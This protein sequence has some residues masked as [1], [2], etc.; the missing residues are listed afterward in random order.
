MSQTGRRV[1]GVA[2]VAAATDVLLEALDA[3]PEGIAIFGADGGLL[4]WNSRYVEVYAHPPGFLRPGLPFEAVVRRIAASGRVPVAIGREGEWIAERLRHQAMPESDFEHRLDDGRWIRVQEKR[5]RNGLTVGIRVDITDLKRREA[6]FRLMF[7]TNPVPILVRDRDGF[8]M[9]AV[10]DAALKLFGYG[11]AAFLALKVGD[12]CALGR[13]APLAEGA[14]WRCVR[15]DGTFVDLLPYSSDFVHAGRPAVIT[16]LVDMTE[17]QRG[18]DDL[19]RTRAF[20][21]SVIETIPSIVFAKDMQDGGRYVLFNR[22]GELQAADDLGRIVGRTDAEIFPPDLATL[23]EDHDAE[24][25]RAG[26][27]CEYEFAAPGRGGSRRVIHTRKVPIAGRAGEAPRYVLGVAEDVTER[28]EMERRLDRAARFDD[29]TGLPNRAAFAGILKGALAARRRTPEGLAL[30]LIDLDGFRVFN[31]ALGHAVGDA[32]LK[33]VGERLAGEMRGDDG[34]ARLGAD[35]FVVVQSGVGERADA[36]SLASR[37]LDLFTRPFPVCGQELMVGATIGIALAPSE[38][39]AEGGADLL[40][41]HAEL[42]LQR[43][44]AGHRGTFHAFEPRMDEEVRGRRALEQDLRGALERG[45]FELHYQPQVDLATELVSGFEALVRWRHPVRG[46]VEPGAFIPVAEETG[47]IVRLGAWVLARACADAAAWPVP[48]RV[49]VNL[50]PVQFITPG[51]PEAVA[52]A[53]ERSGLPPGRLELEITESVRLI[54]NDTNLLVLHAF[55]DAGIQVALDDFGTGFAS[56]SYLRAFPF[57][58]IKID[59]S[60][61]SDIGRDEGCL[62]IVRAATRLARDLGMDTIAEGIETPLQLLQLRQLGCAEGQGYLFGRPMPGAD[63]PALL[64]A[65]P[66]RVVAG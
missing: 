49:A 50:S 57:S 27:Q 28:R 56:L 11:R 48:A 32:L 60:F 36:E 4:F 16:A 9:L 44:K 55:R 25:M 20:L 45:E 58:K 38:A 34:V 18:R 21:D 35:E 24:V 33:A 53:L 5:T 1:N 54:D 39:A 66:R 6:S 15:G 7:E 47:L 13:S 14:P 2:A 64:L 59:R 63:V 26:A 23:F 8:D 46:L 19:D 30:L 37:L 3:L 22:A 65:E 52:A 41:R 12:L 62:A 17:V 43:A 29:L 51:L 10:N 40:L 31:D 61:V 42:A